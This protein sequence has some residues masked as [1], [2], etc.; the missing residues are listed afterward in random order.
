[1]KSRV[2]KVV[3]FNVS[4]ADAKRIGKIVDRAMALANGFNIQIE[5]MDLSMDITATHANGCPLDLA[6][7]LLA[8]NFNF[9]HDVF[10]IRRHMNRDTGRLGD[11]FVP[12]FAKGQHVRRGRIAA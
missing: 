9:T 3:S 2:T 12:R 4:R 11:C 8:D 5:R 1:M 6:D 10:G 7:L